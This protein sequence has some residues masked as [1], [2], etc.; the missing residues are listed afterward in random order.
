MLAVGNALVLP[1]IDDDVAR[2]SQLRQFDETTNILIGRDPIHP[3]D[4]Y[5]W[6]LGLAPARL[7]ELIA[8]RLMSL[9][10][11]RVRVVLYEG[12]RAEETAQ[13]LSEKLAGMGHQVDVICPRGKRNAAYMPLWDRGWAPDGWAAYQGGQRLM[14][15]TQT[16]LESVVALVA[17]ARSHRRPRMQAGEP[18]PTVTEVGEAE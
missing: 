2:A 9:G 16:D 3:L 10:D 11:P 18:L 15:T 17:E 1:A 6:S 4:S 14:S 5:G 8:D 7:A 12:I 13:I